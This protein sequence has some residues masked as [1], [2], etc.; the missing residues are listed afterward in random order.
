MS[1]TQSQTVEKRELPNP[2]QEIAFGQI[3]RL[4]RKMGIGVASPS[5]VKRIAFVLEERAKEIGF[6][7]MMLARQAGRRQITEEDVSLALQ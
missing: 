2:D 3:D 5:A 4:L 6:D 1:E 7:A